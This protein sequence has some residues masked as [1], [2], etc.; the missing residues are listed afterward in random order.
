MTNN[1]EDENEEMMTSHRVKV[2]DGST[3]SSSSSSSSSTSI[4][5][6]LKSKRW[7]VMLTC[8]SLILA[9]ALIICY[10]NYRICCSSLSNLEQYHSSSSSSFLF[11]KC[12][13][14][15]S[16]ASRRDDMNFGHPSPLAASLSSAS[17]I[18]FYDMHNLQHHQH[19]DD[20][21]LTHSLDDSAGR[22]T[23]LGPAGWNSSRLPTHLI[24]WHYDI[25]L[26]INVYTRQFVGYC[27]IR[28]RCNQSISFL[29]VHADTN[30]QFLSDK[31][32]FFLL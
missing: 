9:L 11:L 29:V 15:S 10:I 5:G 26:R 4:R 21:D 2:L 17:D 3:S 23:S 27:A 25:R 18:D 28:V 1:D 32:D 14:S 8:L 24:P 20:T 6:K 22:V 16:S 30:L 31:V 19:R 12:S 13:S 7:I